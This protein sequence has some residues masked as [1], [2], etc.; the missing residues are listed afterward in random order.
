MIKYF[1]RNKG[2][3]NYFSK[4]INDKLIGKKMLL[5]AI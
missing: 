1:Y 3:L 2:K 5:G 4:L